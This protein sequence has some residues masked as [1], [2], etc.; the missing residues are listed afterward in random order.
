MREQSEREEHAAST[1][2]LPCARAR[3]QK[4]G[5]WQPPSGL[6]PER[7]LFVAHDGL[8]FAFLPPSLC[9]PYCQLFEFKR[10]DTRSSTSAL[11]TRCSTTPLRSRRSSVLSVRRRRRVAVLAEVSLSSLPSLSL[12]PPYGYHLPSPPLSSTKLTAG[13]GGGMPGRGGG[14]GELAHSTKGYPADNRTRRTTPWDAPAWARCAGT[15]RARRRP[16]AVEGAMYMI[17][18]VGRAVDRWG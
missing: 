17:A 5:G 12:I 16:G 9:L 7:R 14:G 13:R 1:S 2:C 8:T 15:R 4:E 6:R 10:A 18:V 3:E 11:R